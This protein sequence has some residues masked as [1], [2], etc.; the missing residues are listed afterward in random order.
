MV[1]I[2]PLDIDFLPV[3][4]CEVYEDTPAANEK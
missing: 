4:V 2:I 3:E 1:I